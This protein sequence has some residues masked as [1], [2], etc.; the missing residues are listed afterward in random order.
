MNLKNGKGVMNETDISI[1][2]PYT[3]Q[4]ATR[5]VFQKNRR[6]GRQRSMGKFE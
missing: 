4:T 2:S 1:Q 3:Q 5:P 6:K